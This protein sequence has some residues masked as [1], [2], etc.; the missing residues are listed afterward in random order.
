MVIIIIIIIVTNGW[1]HRVAHSAET[2]DGYDE[3]ESHIP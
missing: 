2:A 1:G 3:S